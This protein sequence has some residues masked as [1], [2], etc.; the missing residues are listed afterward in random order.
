MVNEVAKSG[1]AVPGLA[2]NNI[3][4]IMQLEQEYR[5]QRSRTDR[6]GEVVSRVAGS[7]AFICAH[8]CLFIAWIVINTGMIP[9]I[10]PFD[11]FPFSFLAFLVSLE[12]IFLTAFV[13]MNQNRQSRQEDHWA[14]LNLQIGLLGEQE[15]TKVLQILRA[16]STHLGLKD[17][18]GDRELK[19]MVGKTAVG[20]LA[21]EL[22]ENLERTREKN[23]PVQ[24]D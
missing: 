24:G 23:E 10:A 5:R 13:L 11:P 3:E 22:A 19:E 2:K 14:H 7:I 15:T 4:S 18:A 12:A 16:I 20:P 8:I 21:E 1:K 9:A 6:L 17:L